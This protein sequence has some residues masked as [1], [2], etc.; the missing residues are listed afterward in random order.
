MLKDFWSNGC[1]LLTE[2]NLISRW[3][4][5]ITTVLKLGPVPRKFNS[6]LYQILV[7]LARTTLDCKTVGFVL[8][9]RKKKKAMR[10]ERVSGA[11]STRPSHARK[12]VSGKRKKNRLS[13]FHTMSS[14]WPGGSKMSSSCHKSVHNFTLFVNLIHSVIDCEGE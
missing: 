10:S 13:V 12:G 6:G 2:E 5:A 14:F 7:F 9:I 8:K 4:G 3:A 11:R 1:N